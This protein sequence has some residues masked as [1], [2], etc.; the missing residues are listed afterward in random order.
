MVKKKD[1]FIKKHLTTADLGTKSANMTI[2]RVAQVSV[3][4]YKQQAR[5]MKWAMF[6]P[7]TQKYMIL[8]ETNWDKLTEIFGSDDSDDWLGNK[9]VI[10]VEDILVAGQPK[11]ALRFTDSPD[12]KTVDESPAYADDFV[13]ATKETETEMRERMQS[14]TSEKNRADEKAAAT[15]NNN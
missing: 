8:N 11:K 10:Y 9:V 15:G 2:Q 12:P 7:T 5:V 1:A 13:P 14:E 4:D 6:F 3:Y